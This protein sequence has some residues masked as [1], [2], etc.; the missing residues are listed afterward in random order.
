MACALPA[1]ARVAGGKPVWTA[2][3]RVADGGGWL[4]L[5][6]WYR[7][8]ATAPHA[9]LDDTIRRAADVFGDRC[10][11]GSDW[12]HTMFLERGVRDTS[13]GYAQTWLPVSRALGAARADRVLR[14][15]P[16]LPCA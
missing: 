12:P 1:Q 9:E 7:L 11:W 2:L 13:P 16:P 15:H 3:R 6:G 4:K 10:V 8:A 5:S 14:S